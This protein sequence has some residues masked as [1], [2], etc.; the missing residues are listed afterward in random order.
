MQIANSNA[1]GRKSK[2]IP[3]R[4]EEAAWI[5]DP[6]EFFLLQEMMHR[7]NNELT[8]TIGIVSCAVERSN[9]CDVKAALT[10][11][12]EHLYDHARIYRALQ[13]PSANRSIDAAAY[14]RE[15]CQSISRAKLRH[16]GIE[17]VLVEHPLQL[18]STQCWKLG[19][20]V[21]E[22][23]TNASRHAFTQPGG[24]IRVELKKR[25]TG[26]ECRVADDGSGPE[27]VRPGQGLRI[28][29]QLA[30]GLN[31]SINQRFGAK[32][33]VAIVSFPVEKLIPST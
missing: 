14:L 26:A 23:I 25:G 27:N 9:S 13:M 31:G 24:T 19:L 11:V 18:S 4:V 15:L 6:G 17:L 16:N 7:I 12:I 2:H 29:Q 21:A 28:I 8:S 10:E 32:G 20:I 30:R 33:A 3:I 1:F 22:L 5:S